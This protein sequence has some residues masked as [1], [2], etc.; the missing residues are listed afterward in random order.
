M[1]WRKPLRLRGLMRGSIWRDGR[2]PRRG[3]RRTGSNEP[4]TERSRLSHGS[5][6][7]THITPPGVTLGSKPPRRRSEVLG[8]P[9]GSSDAPHLAPPGMLDGAGGR[10]RRAS[11]EIGGGSTHGRAGVQFCGPSR[12]RVGQR[13]IGTS[14]PHRAF[15]APA[16]AGRSGQ[17]YGAGK[18]VPAW[19]SG[20]FRR[21]WPG[22]GPAVG[23]WASGPWSPSRT[24]RRTR[25]RGPRCR[26]AHAEHH[27]GRRSDRRGG[28]CARTLRTTAAPAARNW[29]TCRGRRTDRSPIM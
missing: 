27:G 6:E 25:W 10:T 13:S 23:R 16:R 1:L 4:I 17:P 5:Q 11:A 7:V 9:P 26:P 15:S 24:S 21:R 20:P 2:Q 29:P 12:I 8:R 19:I 14:R 18:N 22:C 28:G 3:L